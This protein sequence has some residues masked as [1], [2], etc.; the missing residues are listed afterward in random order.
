MKIGMYWCGLGLV[1]GLALAGCQTKTEAD[2][3]PVVARFLMETDATRGAIEVL[4]PVSGVRVRVAPKPVITE[5]D[6]TGVA[7]ARVDLG[8]CL[9][10][11][12]T[13]AAS[14][15]LYRLSAQNLNRRLVLVLNGQPM[16]ARVIDRPLEPGALFIFLEV[17][18][19]RLPVLVQ[20]ITATSQRLQKE[21]ARRS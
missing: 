16:G 6:I 15:D 10:F 20:D 14:R 19:A 9:L 4:L 11:R 1:L 21:A 7:E 12:L 3:P 18:D 8:H 17:P 13:P 2:R 5:Y